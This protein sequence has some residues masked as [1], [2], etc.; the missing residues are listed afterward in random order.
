MGK[1]QQPFIAHPDKTTVSLKWR[2][3]ESCGKKPWAKTVGYRMYPQIHKDVG[4]V[5]AQGFLPQDSPHTQKKIN[6]STLANT[7]FK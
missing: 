5:L 1:F 2:Q 3:G 4:F 6:H 7:A